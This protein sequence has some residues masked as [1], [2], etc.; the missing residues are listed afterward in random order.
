MPETLPSESAS[1]VI[2]TRTCRVCDRPMRPT[3]VLCA[4]CG[5][6]THLRLPERNDATWVDWVLGTFCAILALAVALPTT[7]LIGEPIWSGRFRGGA[8]PAALAISVFNGWLI[9]VPIAATVW[10]W[11]ERVHEDQHY[12][13]IGLREYWQI[14]ALCLSPILVIGLFIGSIWLAMFF[15]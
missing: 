6:P 7:F 13:T 9:G 1:P 2:E 8:F 3:D 11:R 10:R 5:T 14:Q 4:R 12:H 15:W